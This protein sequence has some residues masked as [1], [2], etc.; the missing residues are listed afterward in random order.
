MPANILAFSL[1][2]KI[3]SQ[4]IRRENHGPQILG[5][6]PEA[7]SGADAFQRLR[8]PMASDFRDVPS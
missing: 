6:Y 4:A 8:L 5:W 2:V 3:L 1:E 7:S